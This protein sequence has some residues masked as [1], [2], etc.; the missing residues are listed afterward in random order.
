MQQGGGGSRKSIDAD[1]PVRGAALGSF[2]TGSH[3]QHVRSGNN[4]D[5]V[6]PAHVTLRSEVNASFSIYQVRAAISAPAEPV[7]TI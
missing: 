5:E 2:A 3:Q 1:E 7:S 6:S 4:L